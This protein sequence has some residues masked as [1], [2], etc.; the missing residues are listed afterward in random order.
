MHFSLDAASATSTTVKKSIEDIGKYG[1]ALALRQNKSLDTLFH[2]PRL[3]DGDGGIGHQDDWYEY[4]W[5]QLS[6]GITGSNLKAF[7]ETRLT[8]VTFNYDLSLEHYLFTAA[9]NSYGLADD[10]ATKLLEPIKFVHLYGQL[11]GN[12]FSSAFCYEFNFQNDFRL[13]V[14]DA[15]LIQVIDEQRELELSNF[16]KASDALTKAQRICFLGFGFDETNVRRL[17]L[18]RIFLN[19]AHADDVSANPFPFPEVVATSLG[20]ETSERLANQQL[21]TVELSRTSRP[22]GGFGMYKKKN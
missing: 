7:S 15:A 1:I 2:S 18:A 16:S 6:S 17:G 22:G 8:V 4:L 21:L 9:K 11:S 12:P 20:L 14:K 19:R 10:E 3:R 5:A 13:L